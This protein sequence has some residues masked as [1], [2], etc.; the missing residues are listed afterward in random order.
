MVAG[1]GLEPRSTE[2]ALWD[3]QQDVVKDRIAVDDKSLSTIGGDVRQGGRMAEA[4]IAPE[5]AAAAK[6]WSDHLRGGDEHVPGGFEGQV[7]FTMLGAELEP[8]TEDQVDR[9]EA[10][11]ARIG[12]ATY[13]EFDGWLNLMC[14]HF[15]VGPLSQ[16][17]DEVGIKVAFRLPTKTEM[18][19]RINGVWINSPRCRRYYRRIWPS[20][21]GLLQLPRLVIRERAAQR[22]KWGVADPLFARHLW[23][24]R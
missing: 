3:E 7:V 12:Q 2:R 11:L 9:Y 8:L 24:R 10:A 16:A 19:V 17:A 20:G 13:D 22:A 6:W 1:Q 4:G 15:P 5:V 23:R 18:H 21:W 14:D